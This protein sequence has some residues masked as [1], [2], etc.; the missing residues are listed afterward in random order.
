MIARSVRPVISGPRNPAS[1]PR[2]EVI[3][4]ALRSAARSQYRRLGECSL[5]QPPDHHQHRRRSTFRKRCRWCRAVQDLQARRVRAECGQTQWWRR[6]HRLERHRRGRWRRQRRFRSEHLCRRPDEQ[7]HDRRREW[8][9][10]GIRLHRRGHGRLCRNSRQSYQ[11]Q[12]DQQRHN[13][14]RQWWHR[15][16]VLR[17]GLLRLRGRQGWCRRH[18]YRSYLWQREQ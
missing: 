1:F 6:Q 16:R 7:R 3:W 17:P 2:Q 13:C 12:R 8:R 18:R 10:R 9:Q 14:R 4:L 15:W 11:W 5:S